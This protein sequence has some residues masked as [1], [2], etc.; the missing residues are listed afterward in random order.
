MEGE[1]ADEE[2]RFVEEIKR[3]SEKEE[4]KE[5]DKK[6]CRTGAYRMGATDQLIVKVKAQV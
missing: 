4:R 1:E 3:G 2:V 5:E 6:G